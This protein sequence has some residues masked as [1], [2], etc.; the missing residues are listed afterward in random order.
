MEINHLRNRVIVRD[1][2]ALESPLVTKELL[3]QPLICVRR[4]AID[5]VVRRHHAHDARLYHR[6][7]EA[8][9]KVFPQCS[10]REVY[11]SNVGATF[12]LAMRGEMFRSR[13]DVI[14]VNGWSR[15][16]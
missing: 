14:L 1:N 16:L 2:V 13:D 6:R 4:N 7:L 5:L 3:Q 9:Q 15:S 10:F 11:W 8:R 12:R